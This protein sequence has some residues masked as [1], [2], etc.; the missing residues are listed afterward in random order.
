MEDE[1]VVIAPVKPPYSEDTSGTI[2]LEQLMA[3]PFILR[4]EGSG[5]RQETEAYL[6]RFGYETGALNVV[7]TMDN[8]DA[9]IKAISQ[10]LGI[11]IVSRLSAADYERFG[12]LRMFHLAEGDLRRV[13]YVVHD[14]NRPLSPAGKAFVQYVTQGG[15]QA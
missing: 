2:S 5:T 6:A 8:P 12:L 1:L 3:A 14:K 11:S 13:L 10:G 9:V 7:A 15:T 4:S